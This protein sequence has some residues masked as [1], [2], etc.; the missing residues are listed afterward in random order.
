M[1]TLMCDYCDYEAKGKTEK[2]V[3]DMMWEHI[4]KV[5]PEE[6]EK[7]MKMSNEEQDKM[8]EETMLKIKDE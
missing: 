4:K 2:E 1:K 6:Y 7:G 3:M 5:H 8:K